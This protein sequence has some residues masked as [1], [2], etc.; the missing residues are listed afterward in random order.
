MF[1]LT[2]ATGGWADVP[3]PPVNQTL[4]LV[5]TEF[6]QY[7]TDDCR[8]CHNQN[9]PALPGAGV[10]SDDATNVCVSDTDC[11]AGTCLFDPVP[12]DPT[13]LP[14]RHHLLVGG[15][16]P[17]GT[18][19]KPILGTCVA[20]VCT[21]GDVGATCAVDADCNLPL[22]CTNDQECRDASGLFDDYCTGESEVPKPDADGD[23]VVD[24]TY[25]CL[26]CHN[27]VFDPGTGS[28]V[29]VEDFRD[30]TNCH[31]TQFQPDHP[32]RTQEPNQHHRTVE[33]FSGNC[34]YCHGSLVDRGH[35]D[36]Y[37][38]CTA[39]FCQDGTTACTVDTDCPADGQWETVDAPW[40]PTYD[41]SLVTPWPSGK[42]FGSC[43]VEGTCS[44]TTTDTC[45]SDADCPANETC[46]GALDTMVFCAGD[47]GN[48]CQAGEVCVQDAATY[49]GG[50]DPNAR[51]TEEGNCN[52]CHDSTIDHVGITCDG[53]DP[54]LP[55]TPGTCSNAP[56]QECFK[57]ADCYGPILIN[58][59]THHFTGAT[60]IGCDLCHVVRTPTRTAQD[61][62]ACER[63]HGI[64]S[65][66][67]IQTDSMAAG[68]IGSIVVG[69]EEFG[70][71]HIGSNADCNGCHGFDAP[72]LQALAPQSGP[73]IP[74]IG[75]ADD[76]G[77]EA[78]TPTTVTLGG[79][80][81]TNETMGMP[82]TSEAVLD[83][84]SDNLA[85][86]VTESAMVVDLP[87]LSAGTHMLRAKKYQKLSN[88]A[89]I[90]V[91]PQVVIGSVTC[92]DGAATISGSGFSGYLDAS[93]SPTQVTGDVTTT[94]GTDCSVYSDKRTCN[95][96]TDCS[97]NKRARVCEGGGGDPVTTNETA[98]IN[99][100]TDTQIEA[101]F[102]ACPDDGTVA[103]T[104]VWDITGSVDP[105]D[106]AC[107]DYGDKTSCNADANCHWN[108]KKGCLDG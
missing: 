21:A 71:G 94:G 45:L 26:N 69:A 6:N 15:T 29:I 103:V 23:T 105:P 70:Y 108:K 25:D 33:A 93:D 13:Y 67:N 55:E 77:T 35:F 63:C 12:V 61:M 14:D 22:A 41:P 86:S 28:F 50:G 53:Y 40:I 19:N 80:A 65:L 66:H 43:W 58:H 16:M 97:W 79:V 1:L 98:Q 10:C 49:G 101:Q 18:C 88:P 20:T 107:S 34:Q 72:T 27:V 81:F 32:D 38:V 89:V 44:L 31:Q 9:P 46:V 102:S 91:T 5:D 85:V 37:G 3:P 47:P 42:A 75:S 57:E 39:G 30:C 36:N 64:P 24:I 48:Y 17:I 78:N 100:W 104:T 83:G 92:A 51:L 106:A 62:R 59:D 52:F 84:S 4:G 76:L 60:S 74:F 82:Y 68:N 87:G 73:V 7:V 90:V 11:V 54:N 56:A 96:Q 2:V 8:F 99:S 95:Q